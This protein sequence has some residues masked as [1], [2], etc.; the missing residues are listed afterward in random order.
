M[1]YLYVIAIGILL[2]PTVYAKDLGVHGRVYEIAE[3]NLLQVI[4]SRAQ[5]EVDSGNW[6]KRVEG[7]QKQA[8]KQAARPRGIALPRA[9]KTTSHLYDPSIIVPQ[10]IR[11]ANGRLIRA[12]GTHVNPLDY[13]SMS[14]TLVFIDGDDQK[15]VDWMMSQTSEQPDRY[16]V[17]LTQG[18][19]IDLA[20]SLKRRLFFDQRQTYTQKLAIK[21][22]PAVVYQDGLYLRVDEVALP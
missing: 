11:D 1:K 5:A 12:K 10:D 22:L 16:K 3:E 14:R 2:M 21:T 8:K 20:K 4:L 19:V 18:N 15:Q 13:I 6:A 17:I 9:Q 7:W